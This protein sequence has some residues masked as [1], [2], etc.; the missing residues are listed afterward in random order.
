[1]SQL[2]PDES[3]GSWTFKDEEKSYDQ[4][5]AGQEFLIRHSRFYFS[6]DG[7][8]A[9]GVHEIFG[10]VVMKDRTKNLSSPAD[11]P[12]DI[13]V[14]LLDDDGKWKN[15]VTPTPG[16]KTIYVY[17]EGEVRAIRIILVDGTQKV[18][19]RRLI[20]RFSF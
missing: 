4:D 2:P 17:E 10:K 1:M 13:L 19:A 11:T 7:K 18:V 20:G 16:P 12:S 6:K 5:R 3:D 9:L 15:A 8:W 14:W